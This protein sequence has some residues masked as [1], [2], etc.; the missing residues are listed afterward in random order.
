VVVLE[1]SVPGFNSHV[2]FGDFIDGSRA[3]VESRCRPGQGVQ[4]TPDIPG[5][6]KVK[7][8]FP[9]LVCI[10]ERT[11]SSYTASQCHSTSDRRRGEG[12]RVVRG[13]RVAQAENNLL[14]Q[15]RQK[16]NKNVVRKHERP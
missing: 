4:T 14:M 3:E 6:S 5:I 1:G 13:V 12:T 7:S 8:I 15:E 11:T 2:F 9:T 16:P 10:N